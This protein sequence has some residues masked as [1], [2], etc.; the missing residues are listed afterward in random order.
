MIRFKKDV[1]D[2]LRLPDIPKKKWDGKSS[3]DYGV[4]VAI[5]KNEERCYVVVSFNADEDEEPRIKKV[6]GY[7]IIKNL[8]E[9][10]VVPAYMNDDKVEE[11]DLDDESKKRAAAVM[12]EAKEIEDE[13]TAEQVEMPD[14]EY[15]FDSIH[16]DEEGRAF[17]ESYNK[18]NRIKGAIPRKHDAIVMRLGVIWTELNNKK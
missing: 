2:Y 15:F 6:F 10:F 11:M 13:G 12:K 7:D 5:T 16:S 9:V 3:F 1:C 18:K 4:G 14:N 8:D 17:I